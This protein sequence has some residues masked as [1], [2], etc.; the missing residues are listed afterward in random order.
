VELFASDVAD[1]LRTGPYRPHLPHPRGCW[2][3]ASTEAEVVR[4]PTDP[5][6]GEQVVEVMALPPGRAAGYLASMIRVMPT[7]SA[8]PAR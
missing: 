2:A 1:S 4:P 7:S 6:D 8:S 5:A 3:Y